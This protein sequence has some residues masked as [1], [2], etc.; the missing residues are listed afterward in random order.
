MK[1]YQNW[2]KK[3]ESHTRTD[4]KDIIWVLNEHLTLPLQNTTRTTMLNNFN[5]SR[6][7]KNLNNKISDSEMKA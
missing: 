5:Q 3:A 2:T 7:E 1:K 6:T 4:P